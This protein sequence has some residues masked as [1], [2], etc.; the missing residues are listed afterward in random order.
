MLR[1]GRKPIN[2]NQCLV[3]C[4]LDSEQADVHIINAVFFSVYLSGRKVFCGSLRVLTDLVFLFA[5]D[6]DENNHYTCSGR[7][8][9]SCKMISGILF[10]TK[11]R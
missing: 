3:L 8:C 2:Q 10:D 4:M 5:G 1:L 9:N 6:T 7:C 11:C